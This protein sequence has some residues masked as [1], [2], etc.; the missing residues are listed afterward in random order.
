MPNVIVGHGV[1]PQQID[2]FPSKCE[3]SRKGALYIRPK[4][5]VE[6]TNDELDHIKDKY[7]DLYKRLRVVESVVVRRQAS[8]EKP[9]EVAVLLGET[10]SKAKK[11]KLDKKS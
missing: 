4:S 9:K 7:K 6:M 8:K 11:D 3:R 2:D 5:T 1:T 10:S